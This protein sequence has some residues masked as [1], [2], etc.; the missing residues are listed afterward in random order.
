MTWLRVDL[1]SA[2]VSAGELAQLQDMF[3][4]SWTTMGTPKGASMWLFNHNKEGATLYF[5]PGAVSFF[6]T[7]L[8]RFRPVAVSQPPLELCTVL[9][10]RAGSRRV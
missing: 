2:D 4:D 7:T 9:A 1:S 3:A 5:S 8:N 10:A 6:E